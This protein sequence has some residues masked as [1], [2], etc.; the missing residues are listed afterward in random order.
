MNG[1]TV[2]NRA[3]RWPARSNVVDVVPVALVVLAE[4]AWISAVGGLLQEY[5][6]HEPVLGIPELAAFVVS[7][8]VGARLLGRRLGPRWPLAGLG[9]IVVAAIV[10]SMVAPGAREAVT[11][12]VGP[13]FAAH[14]AGWLGGVAVLRGYAH[15]RLPIAQGTLVHLLALG[16]P[17]L[18]LVTLAGGLIA[19]PFRGR[20]L[21][22]TLIAAIVFIVATTLA[23]ALARL[24]AIGQESGFDWRRNPAWLGLMLTLLALAIAAALPLS[25]VAGTV[26][27][28]L[29]SVAIGPLLLV[30]LATGFDR[31]ARRVI[32][33]FA[34]VGVAVY[35]LVAL[36]GSAGAPRDRN[37][38][39]TGGPS[40]PS[41]AE[42]VMTM[43][44]GGLLLLVAIIAVLVLAAAWMRRT[45]P[46]DADLVDEIRT[47]DRGVDGA[48]PRRRR[49]WIGRRAEPTGAAAAYV[50]LVEDLDRHPTVRRDVGETPAEHAARLRAA[51]HSELSLDLLAADYALAR[52]GEVE[53]SAREDRRGLARW[54]MLRRRL[55]G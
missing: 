14:P 4:A 39:G 43:S 38:I 17:G 24:T 21:A 55:P 25:A 7:G 5:A 37:P 18:V 35:V 26:V 47:I 41:V 3:S 40:Q 23:L 51:G 20:F 16:V 9:L 1:A 31:T 15:A 2:P 28:T 42:Q 49:R 54:R 53:L 46:P 52:Y 6:F 50:A 13:V 48:G 34:M 44:L 22:D 27:Q 33:F 19:D 29:L 30:G 45:R 10:G 8:I 12:G 36:F 11:A 32:L